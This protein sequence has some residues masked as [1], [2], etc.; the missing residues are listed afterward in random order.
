[1]TGKDLKNKLEL[2]GMP[3]RQIAEALGISEQNLQNKMSSA[4]IKVSFL[5]K[6]SKVLHKS[7]YSLLEGQDFYREGSMLRSNDEQPLPYPSSAS[8][9]SGEDSFIYKMYEKEKEENKA[10]FEEVGGLKERIRT[11]ES[12]L[13]EYE[14]TST[15]LKGAIQ[16]PCPAAKNVSTKKSSLPNADN[17]TSVTAR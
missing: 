9:P 8:I 1:M 5:C 7:V 14:S 13:Q 12:Q 2:T 11:L 17:V 16:E 6:I 10:L 4:D 3:F 15:P